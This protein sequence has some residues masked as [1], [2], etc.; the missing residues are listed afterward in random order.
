M[1]DGSRRQTVL[2]VAVATGAVVLLFAAAVA[3]FTRDQVSKS[4]PTSTAPAG[5]P[6]PLAS[7][8]MSPPGFYAHADVSKLPALDVPWVKR[9]DALDRGPDY[10]VRRGEL[11]PIMSNQGPGGTDSAGVDHLGVPINVVDAATPRLE[12]RFGVSP[13]APEWLTG[14]VVNIATYASISTEGA[15]PSPE[16]LKFQGWPTGPIWD[17]Y[18]F[19]IDA[20]SC[21]LYETIGIRG[22][23]PY[24]PV[25]Q[26]F[27]PPYTVEGAVTWD[28]RTLTPLFRERPLGVGATLTPISPLVVRFDETSRAAAGGA[29]IDHAIHWAG[30]ACRGG[31]RVLGQAFVWPARFTDCT[32][33]IDPDAPPYGA[34][35]RLRADYPT[36]DLDPQAAAIV[37]AMKTHGLILGDGG[38]QGYYVEPAPCPKLDNNR[39]QCWT[40]DTIEQLQAVD[41]ADLEAVDTSSLPADPGAGI[42]DPTFWELKAGA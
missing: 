6:C 11:R 3:V 35:F 14:S 40:K 13:L 10:G 27:Y 28:L 25:N 32:G 24:D 19:S 7:G 21:L 26:R 5:V 39:K 9:A 33:D 18:M 2:I 31:E 34:W 41:V 36:D 1:L 42:G 29:P 17:H 38:S 23:L 16:R 8:S 12:Y 15:Y 30:V 22:V 37:N 4:T 20:D